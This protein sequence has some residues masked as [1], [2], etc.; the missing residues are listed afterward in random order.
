MAPT[1]EPIVLVA[2]TRATRRPGSPPAEAAA[3]VS[4]K[5]APHRMVAG[6]MAMAAR[7]ASNAKVSAGDDR[8]PGRNV[9]VG[10][11]IGS[12]SAIAREA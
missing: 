8:T 7:S 3:T 11:S 4:G 1:S 6:S 9:A 10:C 12:H 2:F 5:L